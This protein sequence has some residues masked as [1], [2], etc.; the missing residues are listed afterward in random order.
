MNIRSRNRAR[1]EFSM[2]SL[3]DIIFLLLIFFLLT[4]KLVTIN[5]LNLQLP[6]A[7]TKAPSPSANVV[8]S[9]DGNSNYFV[10]KQA[11]NA[12][13]LQTVINQHIADKKSSEGAEKVTIILEAEKSTPVE[14]VVT[15][16]DIANKIKA[17]MVLATE[18]KK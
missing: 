13:Q 14:E 2:A 9:I 1:A 17:P 3:T 4:S 15:V 12:S 10:E 5:A 11:V 6:G 8:V 18:P 16:M 7:N